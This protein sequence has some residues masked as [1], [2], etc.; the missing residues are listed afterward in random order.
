VT[1][2]GAARVF[3]D[4]DAIQP[5]E[6]FRRVLDER[7]EHVDALLAVIGP[8]WLTDRLEDPDD[9]V[10]LE[11][12]TAI[13]RGIP[14]IPVLVGGAQIPAAPA[15]PLAL[16]A[17]AGHQAAV[18]H[19]LHFQADLDMLIDRLAAIAG[20]AARRRLAP[21]Q[22][23]GEAPW[24]C[25]DPDWRSDGDEAPWPAIAVGVPDPD[26][27][28]TLLE[29]MLERL[30]R[31]FGIIVP[32]IAIGTADEPV[33]RL[34]GSPPRGGEDAVAALEAAIRDDPKAVVG[35]QEMA[36]LLTALDPDVLDA[37]LAEPGALSD[38]VHVCRA[39]LA[40]Y[41]S[42]GP[43]ATIVAG[44]RRLR[45][46][47]TPLV[48]I[49]EELRR[50]PE[51]RA[52]LPGND[53]LSELVPLGADHEREFARSLDLGAEQP[54]LAMEPAA[55]QAVLQSVQESLADVPG[56]AA[57]V[58]ENAAIRPFVRSLISLQWAYLPV[59]SRREVLA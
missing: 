52:E 44:Y 46:M 29:P 25:R 34:A 23:G 14:L 27:F 7:L 37:V 2:F 36:S 28:S 43:L 42:I 12:A 17:L 31:R 32:G 9:P 6:Q 56:D 26:G 4:I 18:L 3:R 41:V 15:L 5:G 35:H 55:T 51:L 11:I 53:G 58:V 16:A 21:R 54:L 13:E 40:E 19:E 48:E 24:R 8:H 33:V 38:L 1:E 59:L 10:R 22:V 57:I 49:V 20:T 30:W 47:G 45:P 50:T 39:L